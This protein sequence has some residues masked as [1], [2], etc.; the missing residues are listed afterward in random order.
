MAQSSAVSCVAS[1]GLLTSAPNLSSALITSTLPFWAAKMMGSLPSL[2][3]GE[4]TILMMS[5]LW[6][7]F[8]SWRMHTMPLTLAVCTYSSKSLMRI[9]SSPASNSDTMCGWLKWKAASRGVPVVPFIVKSAPAALSRATMPRSPER[10]AKCMAVS[11]RWFWRLT[12]APFERSHFTTAPRRLRQA[13]KSG[14]SRKLLRQFTSWPFSRKRPPR[15]WNM[16]HCCKPTRMP[17]R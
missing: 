3:M 1:S 4:L 10:A 9:V 2:V 15:R 16:S 13:S 11:W 5:T 6:R 17:Q 7:T 8:D 12:S 14:D